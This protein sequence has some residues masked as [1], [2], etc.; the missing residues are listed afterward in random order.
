[1][2]NMPSGRKPNLAIFLSGGGSNAEK[3]LADAEV[4]NAA[5]V[6]VLVTDAPEK[7]RAGLIAD[8]LEGTRIVLLQ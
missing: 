7:S 8:E 6:V 3:L 2:D 4:R 5:N 1:M